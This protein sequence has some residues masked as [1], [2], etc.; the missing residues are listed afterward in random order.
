[1]CYWD[2][3]QIKNK[4]Q[5]RALC[6]MISFFMFLGYFIK[7]CWNYT[8]DFILLAYLLWILTTTR[9]VLLADGNHF[10]LYKVCAYSIFIQGP[11][12]FEAQ[13]K[14]WTSEVCII[15]LTK[16]NIIKLNK[17]V[18]EK[19]IHKRGSPCDRACFSGRKW[20]VPKA[21]SAVPN[22]DLG[23]QNMCS[24]REMN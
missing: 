6:N 16:I 18:L 10:F 9:N 5:I 20:V 14:R 4:D 24:G 13:M 12:H 21:I 11:I 19:T 23:V 7:C 2:N 3:L 8:V 15:F 1:M 17:W 22:C